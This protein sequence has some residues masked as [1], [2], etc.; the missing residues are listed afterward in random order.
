MTTESVNFYRKRENVYSL[1]S[2]LHVLE[3][4]ARVLICLVTSYNSTSWTIWAWL[5][6]GV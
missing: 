4:I 3:R 6:V 2:S 1:T 5:K